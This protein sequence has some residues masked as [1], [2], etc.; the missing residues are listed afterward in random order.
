MILSLVLTLLGIVSSI[1]SYLSAVNNI[2]SR[3]TIHYGF[4]IFS[5]I[6]FIKS[7][8]DWLYY[9]KREEE[10]KKYGNFKSNSDGNINENVLNRYLNN[11]K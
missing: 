5:F 9:R 8:A 11:R 4:I 7:F 6:V 10:I 1:Y 3:Y 2:N